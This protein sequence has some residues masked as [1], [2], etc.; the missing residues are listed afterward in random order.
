MKAKTRI[1][2]ECAIMVSLATVLSF[3][4]IY[5][6]L[7]GGSVTLLSMLPI[8]LISFRWGVPAGV[9][10]A[11]VYSIIQLLLGLGTIAYVPTPMGICGAVVLDYI[12]P[13]TVLGLAGI[14]YKNGMDKKKALI[15]ILAGTI[16]VLALRFI[17]HVISGG[18]VWYELTKENNWNEYVHQYSKWAYSLLYNITYMGPEAALTILA[19]PSILKLK[20]IYKK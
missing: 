20:E 3:I 19:S 13:F 11:F 9:G 12:I 14:F 1:L 18:I 17:S 5:E 15:S 8:I 2:V 10:S 4:K 6:A 16:M 7:L